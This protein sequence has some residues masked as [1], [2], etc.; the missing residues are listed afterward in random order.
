[1]RPHLTDVT[2][3]NEQSEEQT[4]PAQYHQA[5]MCTRQAGKAIIRVVDRCN[6]AKENENLDLSDCSLM[7]VP[8]A[9]F[10]LMRNTNLKT[11]D[12]SSNVITKIPPQIAFK[13]SCIRKLDVSKNRMS[14][15]PEE[16]GQL[17][18]LSILNISHNAFVSLPRIVYTLPKLEILNAEKNYIADVEA[19]LLKDRVC[20]KT[21]NLRENPL[22]KE[23]QD[24]LA[25]IN[26]ITI[27]LSPRIEEEWE[28]TDGF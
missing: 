13:F 25:S 17:E 24:E 11:C 22:T 4:M 7:Q 12:L 1:M 15:I 14:K 18:Q 20:L 19:K 28:K 21:V 26:T 5:M 6:D 23:T 8:D 9:I 10:L 16:L 27:H 2:N 3:N